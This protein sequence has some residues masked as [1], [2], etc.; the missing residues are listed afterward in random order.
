MKMKVIRTRLTGKHLPVR[1][2]LGLIL[3]ILF[4]MYFRHIILIFEVSGNAK[5][6]SRLKLIQQLQK[7]G[8]GFSILI[9]R[10][11]SQRSQHTTLNSTRGEPSE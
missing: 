3:L 5:T 1:A 8:V 7:G 9:H 10:Q 4:P 2:V 11:R 6:T